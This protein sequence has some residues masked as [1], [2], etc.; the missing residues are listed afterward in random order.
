MPAAGQQIA[1]PYDSEARWST[2]REIEWVGYKVHLTETCD[3]IF[4]HLITRVE[5]TVA[6][7][8]DDQVVAKIH[9]DLADK[10]RL[11]SQH[12]IDTGYTVL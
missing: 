5:T 2:K 9:T 11:P 10:D 3:D 4:P 7:I 12:I 8:P 6:T 1:S